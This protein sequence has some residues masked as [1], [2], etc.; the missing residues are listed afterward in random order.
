[1]I[2][3]FPKFFESAPDAYVII[4]ATPEFTIVDANDAYLR[5]T[6]TER[7]QIVDR[8][9]FDVFADRTGGEGGDSEELIRDSLRTAITTR[10]RQEIALHRYDIRRFGGEGVAY[11]RRHWRMCVVP[12]PGPDGAVAQLLQRL[13]DVTAYVDAEAKRQDVE[14][15]HRSL[16]EQA[17]AARREVAERGHE[18]ARTHQQLEAN[19]RKLQETEVRLQAAAT[20]GRI[21]TWIWEPQSDRIHADANVAEWYHVPPHVANGGPFAAFLA[22]VHPDDVTSFKDNMQ[23]ALREGFTFDV[24]FRVRGES[25]DW[26]WVAVRGRVE[27]DSERRAVRLVGIA[28]DISELRQMREALTEVKERLQLAADAAEIGTFSWSLPPGNI[29]ANAKCKEHFGLGPEAEIN[30]ERLFG[31][32]HPDDR[33]PAREAIGRSIT[34]SRTFDLE[35]RTM[36]SDGQIRWLRAKGRAYYDAKG[37]ATRFDGITIDNTA[38]RQI[39]A[40]LQGSEARYRLLVEILQDYAVFMQDDEAHVTSWNPGAQRLLGYAEEEIIGRSARIFFTPE[41]IAR[42]EDQKEINTAKATGRAND[43]RWHMRKDGSRFFV[44]GMMVALLDDSGRRIGLAK[45]MRDITDRQNAAAER[46]RLLESERAARA[47]AERASRLKDDFLAT[48]SHELRTPLNAIL[49]WTQILKEGAEASSEVAQ[50]LEVIDR[51]TRLQAE[52]IEDLLDM[53]RI[54]SGKVRLNVRP[55]DMAEVVDSAVASVRT[56]AADKRIALTV[57]RQGDATDVQGDRRRLQQ[58]LLNLL[59]NAIK[60]TPAGGR[61]DLVLGGDAGKFTAVVSDTGVGI[62]PE[63]LPHVFERFRQEDAST[64]RRYGGLGLGLAIVK[65]L[66]DLHGGIVEAQSEGEGRGATFRVT[67][68]RT[69]PQAVE[70]PSESPV[71]TGASPGLERVDLQG[72][73][74]L[75]VDDEPD[76][77][78]LVKRVLE[79][80]HADVRSAS[81]MDEA[82]RVFLNFHPHII[83]SDIGMPTHDG[84][85]LIRRVRELPGGDKVGAAALTALA[86]NEDVDR[87]LNAG[88]QTHVAKPVEPA[89]LVAVTASLAGIQSKSGG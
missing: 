68:P 77:A 12:I 53:S 25:S 2:T 33:E 32:L 74:V 51:N 56:T 26:R 54:V 3:D 36:A 40:D 66:V 82:L 61:V 64:T 81:S 1:M 41:D 4:T 21:G 22:A 46:D 72:V 69:P 76:S 73:K 83:L 58:V 71:S 79:G 30:P 47:E 59:S 15:A 7:A 44:T 6:M 89:K 84:Y 43:D 29:V 37:E 14:R 23:Q 60:F 16:L 80:C 70:H 52:L 10:K 48:L 75:V 11:E 28:T 63:F 38:T 42:G 39:Q 85:E 24:E 86:R 27:R 67:L 18:L 49:G 20:S 62:R 31:I 78:S 88:F 19:A 34:E 65:Q 9:V 50:G 5:V 55:V 87:A 35:F 57:T 13:E 17:E 45:I 8:P